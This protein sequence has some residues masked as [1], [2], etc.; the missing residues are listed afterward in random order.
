MR[1]PDVS[2]VLPTHRRPA[3]WLGRAVE[4]A[5]RQRGVHVEVVV[6]NDGGPREGIPGDLRTARPVR[7]L[8]LAR[9]VGPGRAREI[10]RAAARASRIA[11]LDDDDEYAPDHLRR[12]VGAGARIAYSVGVREVVRDGVVVRRDTPCMYSFDRRALL[13]GNYIP[14]PAVI[15]DRDVGGFAGEPVLEDWAFLLRA[16]RHIRPAFVPEAT[17][18]YRHRVAGSNRTN[19]DADRTI[20]DIYSRTRGECGPAVL[21]RRALALARRERRRT[22]GLKP[23]DPVDFSWMFPDA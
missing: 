11:Y 9:N 6:V 19:L 23:W 16:T 14:L 10:G 1:R 12:L 17:V 2:V 8:D 4:S 15:H 21:E 7:V 22:Q 3:E 18:T 20:L 5:L 13:V